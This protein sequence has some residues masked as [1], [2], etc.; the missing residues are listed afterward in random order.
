VL[1]SGLRELQRVRYE[2]EN[3]FVMP[4]LLERWVEDDMGGPELFA[5]V[6]LAMMMEPLR[7]CGNGPRGAGLTMARERLSVRECR[8][9]FIPTFL[10]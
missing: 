9:C 6:R 2:S 3:Y 5:T 4:D 1:G 7:W 10:Q 8:N